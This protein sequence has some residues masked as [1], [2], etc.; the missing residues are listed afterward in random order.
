MRGLY[1]AIVIPKKSQTS[2]IAPKLQEVVVARSFLDWNLLV[3][4]QG[5]FKLGALSFNMSPVI[6]K[7]LSL[8]ACVVLVFKPWI[9][10]TMGSNKPCLHLIGR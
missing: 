4:E 7:R 6:D 10:K 1:F 8:Y 5:V 9:L 2:S 3:P